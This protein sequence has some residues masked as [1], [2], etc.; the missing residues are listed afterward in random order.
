MRP[1]GKF[2]NSL[3]NFLTC[4]CADVV[5]FPREGGVGEQADTYIESNT[6]FS[7]FSE[8]G[9]IFPYSL[10]RRNVP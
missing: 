2:C 6:S 5:Y 3:Q 7:L 10:N 8:G 4:K 1:K 9:L